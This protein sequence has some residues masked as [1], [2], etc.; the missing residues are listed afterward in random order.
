MT[1]RAVVLARGLGQR[2]R[3]ADDRAALDPDQQR[4]AEA[5]RKALMPIGGRPFLDY[6][7]GAVADAGLTRVAIVVA[8]DHEAFRRHYRDSNPPSRLSIDFIV[9][10]EARGT[11]DAVV[12]VEAWT[13]GEPFLTVNGDNVYP[14]AVLHG[15]AALAEPGLAVFQADDLVRTSNI[16]PDRIPA[17]GLALVDRDGFLAELIEKPPAG[18]LVEAVAPSGISMNSWRFDSRIFRFC[19]D[20]PPSPRG[21]VELPGA[22][23]RAIRYGMRF[24]AIPAKGPVLDLSRRA[25]AAE[26]SRRLSAAQ[27]RL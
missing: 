15:L 18:R 3:Q 24:R 14:V 12:A 2:L 10:E 19:R 13:G 20:V 17:F 4:A 26:L 23:A 22:V 9:Q 8:P 7:L 6:L 25:D 5:G 27:V 21:E 16:P 1:S 11:A